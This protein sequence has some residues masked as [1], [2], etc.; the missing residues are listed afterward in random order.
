MLNRHSDPIFWIHVPKHNQLKFILQFWL[1]CM[2]QKLSCPSDD[3][4]MPHMQNSSSAD[5][6]AILIY[7]N[8]LQSTV[9]QETLL[10]IHFT[11]AHA[12]EQIYLPHCIHVPLYY[13]CYLHIDPYYYIHIYMC[14]CVCV[15]KISNLYSPCQC[16]ICPSNKYVPQMPHM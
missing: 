4:Y 3:T 11:L 13:N 2:Y 5:E 6:T 8:I 15:S 9:W 16:H 7:I 12:P 1:L 14:V 10:P